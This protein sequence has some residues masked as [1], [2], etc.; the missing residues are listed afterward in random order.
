MTRI[1]PDQNDHNWGLS[2]HI[3]QP[4]TS[5]PIL[6]RHQHYKKPGIYTFTHLV[7]VPDL[8]TTKEDVKEL[9]KHYNP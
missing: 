8:Q 2:V 5:I 9:R 3:K 7:L 4:N 6:K 1:H